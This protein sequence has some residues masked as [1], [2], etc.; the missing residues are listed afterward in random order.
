MS[1]TEPAVVVRELSTLDECRSVDPVL[2]SVWG[3]ETPRLGVELLRALTHAGGYAAGAYLG[4]DLVGV[5]VGFLAYAEEMSLHSHVTGVT[6]QARGRGV[7][8]T[9]KSHQRSWALDRGIHA[10]TWTFDPLVRRNAWFNMG[11]LGARPVEYLVDFYGPMPD[12][13]NAGSPSDRLLVAWNVSAP[14]P[15][16]EIVE[17]PGAVIAVPEGIEHLRSTDPAAAHRW[18]LRLREQLQGPVAAGQVVGFRRTEGYVL[19]P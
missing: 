16:D 5:S 9:L 14:L 6:A 19:G 8:M 10:I 18:R 4:A 13:I 12:S 7:G 1:D 15:T 2:A 3:P 17:T 11:R